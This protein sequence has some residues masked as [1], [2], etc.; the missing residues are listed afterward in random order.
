MNAKSATSYDSYRSRTGIKIT[1]PIKNLLKSDTS[2]VAGRN[3]V[4]A[5]IDLSKYLREK[6]VRLH[7][8]SEESFIK[9]FFPFN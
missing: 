6:K 2:A 8:I 1:Y 5:I 3:V 4:E 9:D 7:R